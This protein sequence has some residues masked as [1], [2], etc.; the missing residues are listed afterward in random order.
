MA[1]NV[2]PSL[3][4]PKPPNGKT[5]AAALQTLRRPPGRRANSLL[6]GNQITGLYRLALDLDTGVQRLGVEVL[7]GLSAK[8]WCRQRIAVEGE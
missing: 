2:W 1:P 3:E 6:S 4:L 5:I 8:H 7:S